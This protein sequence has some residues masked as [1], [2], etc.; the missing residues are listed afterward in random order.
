MGLEAMAFG[1]PVV[2][3]NAGGVS[4]W[5]EDGVTGLGVRAGDPEALAAALG[6]VLD[7]PALASRMGRA[8]RAELDRVYTEEHHVSALESAYE[9]TRRATGRAS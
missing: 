5:L 7:D 3:S 2:A 1:K 4:E 9:A 8:G 6:R